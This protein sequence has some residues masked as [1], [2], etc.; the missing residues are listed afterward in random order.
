MT[1]ILHRAGEPFVQPE[2][3]PDQ[4]PDAGFIYILLSEHGYYKIGKTVNLTTRFT[5]L[6]K[7]YKFTFELV[8]AVH[9]PNM[10]WVTE[11]QLLYKYRAKRVK[12]MKDWFTL[13]QEDIDYV[14]GLAS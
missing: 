4:T 11:Q 1:I 5:R 9:L 14:K 13:S 7:K 12:G 10:C 2:P 8:C 6:R 3:D